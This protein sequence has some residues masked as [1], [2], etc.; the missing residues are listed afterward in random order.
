MQRRWLSI[1]KRCIASMEFAIASLSN[2][3]K[4]ATA[5][6]KFGLARILVPLRPLIKIMP[7]L[8]ASPF[9]GTV[10][11]SKRATSP[12][13]R[14]VPFSP[15]RRFSMRRLRRLRFLRVV[16][17]TRNAS[18]RMGLKELANPT[19]YRKT[20]AFRVFSLLLSEFVRT[21]HWFKD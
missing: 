6:K 16:E 8:A 13:V 20:R 1:S 18:V 3:G 7:N 10:E 21:A 2:S 17:F 9:R 14:P 5:M 11:S 12:L 15:S 4:H 19:S